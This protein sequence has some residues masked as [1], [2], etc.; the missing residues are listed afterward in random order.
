MSSPGED[1]DRLTQAREKALRLL[2]VRNRS[3]KELRQ[4]LLAGGFPDAVIDRV[5]ERLGEAGLVDDRKFALERARAM[6]KGKGWGPRKLRAD[7]LQRGVAAE[8]AD[9]AVDQAYGKQSS[10]EIMKRLARKRFGGEVFTSG[11]DR[12][13]RGKA[14]RYLLQKGFEPDEVYAL[15]DSD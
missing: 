5:L 4:R 13:A 10:S 9:E 11:A 15:F 3:R 1:S 2:G 7:L 8:V 12:K 14:V 6:G